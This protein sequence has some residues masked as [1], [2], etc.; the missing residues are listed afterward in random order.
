M[1]TLTQAASVLGAA[2]SVGLSAIGPG[3]GQGTAAG[4]AV[5]GI[6]RQ[7]EAEGKIRGAL[8]WPKVFAGSGRAAK[9]P[10]PTVWFT[11]WFSTTN[12]W[13]HFGRAAHFAHFGLFVDDQ[14]LDTFAHFGPFSVFRQNP[15]PWQ[16][17][18]GELELP[19]ASALLAQ[20]FNR[21][22]NSRAAF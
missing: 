18:V 16:S 10:A 2:I 19:V 22:I 14:Q 17:G 3:M 1:E 5:E 6:A 7:P 21:N 13:I 8:G 20:L 12:S 15:K 9:I 4:Y 11:R